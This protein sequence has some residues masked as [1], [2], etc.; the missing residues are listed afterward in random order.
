MPDEAAL[1]SAHLSRYDALLRTSKTLATHRTIGELVRVLGEELHP[2]IPFDYLALLLHDERS[3]ELRLVIL[4]PPGLAP[5]IVSKPIAEHGPAATVWETQKTAVVP[6]PEKGPLHQVPAYLRSQGLRMACYLPL[7]TAHRQI[8]ILAF[9]SR[10]DAVYTDDTVAFMEQVAAIVAIAV[11]NGINRDEAQRYELEVREERDR[12]QFLL[13]INNLLISQPDYRTLLETICDTVQRIAEADHVGVALYD[14]DSEQLRLDLIYDKAHGFST[15]GATIPLNE[16]AA[17]IT[18]QRGTAGIFRR[19]EMEQ[20][21]WIGA[22]LMKTEGVES[23]CCVPLVTRNGKLGTLYV[24][25]PGPDAFS[26]G[27]VTLLGHA[28]TQIAIALENAR[29]YERLASLNAQLVDE[30]QYLEVELQHEFG[31]IVGTSPALRNVLSA[32]KTVAPTDTTVLLLGETGTGKEL[33]ARAIHRL[34]AR[35]DRPFVRTSVAALP[36]TLLESELFGHEKGAFTGA[37]V[38]RAGRLEVANRGTLFLDEVGDIPMEMQPKLLRVLQERE[39]ERLGSTRTQRIDVRIVAATNRDFDRMIEEGSFRSDLYYRLSVFPITIPPLRERA[40]DIPA[41][42][43]HFV[44]QCARRLGRA[45]PTIPDAVMDALVRW[46]WPGNIRELQNV[47]ERAVILSQGGTLVLPFQDLK[48]KTSKT[49]TSP[50]PAATLK[51]AE[52]ETIIRALR[53]SGGV[54]A[55]PSGAAARLGLQRTTLQSKMRKLGIKRPP[56]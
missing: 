30:K 16:S 51:D 11:E 8:G 43:W 24:G 12:L 20:R 28:S 45:V 4:E 37:A 49:S 14:P 40:G 41:L 46:N 3:N 32:V 48:A 55:G 47:I 56:F 19:T 17:G 27:D 18:F 34:S 22:S 54:I 6:I 7:T 26:E 21:G 33:F 25:S 35:R 2:I 53:E 10:S 1:D 38:S 52:R 29:A 36:A 31:E 13:D 39:F 9:G 15:S 50:K 5:P 42:A 23:M 44:T